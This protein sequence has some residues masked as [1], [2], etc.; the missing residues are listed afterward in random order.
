M[1]LGVRRGKRV[2]ADAA[3]PAQRC[4]RDKAFVAL[5]RPFD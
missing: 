3:Q 2:F 5:K 4:G 1:S